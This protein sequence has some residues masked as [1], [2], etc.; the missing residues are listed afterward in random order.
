MLNLSWWGALRG[1]A[2]RAADHYV[3]ELNKY[4]Y[5]TSS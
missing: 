2:A 3:F 1:V 4:L 5:L